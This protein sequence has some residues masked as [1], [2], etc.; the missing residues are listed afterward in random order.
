M[1]MIDLDEVMQIVRDHEKNKPFY[2]VQRLQR[3]MVH[4][5]QGFNGTPDS[6]LSKPSLSSMENGSIA[7][8][9][10]TCGI[11]PS[12]GKRFAIIQ[13]GASIT[14]LNAEYMK[15]I[16]GVAAAEQRWTRRNNPQC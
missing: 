11:A 10:Q 14:S 2:S 15:L 9:R 13:S 7:T 1:R 3:G 16:K 8:E 4:G 6:L 12:A 5:A